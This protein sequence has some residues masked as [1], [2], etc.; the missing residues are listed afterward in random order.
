VRAFVHPFGLILPIDSRS[1][2]F[3]SNLC[4]PLGQPSRSSL[5]VSL[6]AKPLG[7][8][9]AFVCCQRPV[10]TPT[11]TY[12]R[13]LGMLNRLSTLCTLHLRSQ[14][15]CSP[16]LPGVPCDAS[17]LAK[18]FFRVCQV[19]PAFW[20]NPWEGQSC[21]CAV[22]GS[23]GISLVHISAPLGCSI[24]YLRSVR[25][26]PA[27]KGFARGYFALYHVSNYTLC[28]ASISSLYQASCELYS[29]P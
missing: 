4:S 1:E 16:V 25:H 9:I 21:L 17:L 15:F 12:L 13:T 14:G 7:W 2:L 5:S 6:L 18:P 19:M 24:V 22:S 28:E 3:G 8:A 26:I 29:D 11:G 20:P 10:W 27:P 23:F